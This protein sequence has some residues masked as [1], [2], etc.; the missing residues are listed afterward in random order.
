M[1][2][3]SPDLLWMVVL[4][5]LIAFVLA[6]GIGANDVANSFGTSVGS[7][8]LT[9]RQACVLA[10]ICE[11][12][13]AVLIGYKV[14]DT[15]RKGILEVGLYEGAE[16]E[17]MLGCVAALASSAIW[18]L[19]ATFLKL[20]ISGT[21]SIV[22]STIGFSL[23]ARGTQGLKW[24]TLATI[25][26][27]WFISPVMSGLV[28]I[29]LFLAIRKFIL[30]ARD[31]LKAGFRSLP[32]FYGVTFFI[33][34]I[35]VVLD[36]PKLLYMD[37]I[38]TGI[39]IGASVALSL[40][41]AL[42]TQLIVVPIQKRKIAKQLRAQNPVKFNFED[43]VESSPS[44]SPKKNRRPLSLVSDG[45]QLPAIAEITELVSLTDN[46]PKTFKL[47]PYGLNKNG[48]VTTP[49]N[50]Y[51]AD[52]YKINPEIIKKAED[53]LGKASLD[54]TDLTITSL[55]FID[56][57][58]QNG[59]GNG[60]LQ[61]GNRNNNTNG[62]VMNG[63]GKASQLQD[64]FKPG[65]KSPLLD[66]KSF[67]H[68]NELPAHQ[69]QLL[70]SNQ[71]P[72]CVAN[73][74]ITQTAM[75]TSTTNT[76]TTTLITPA[77]LAIA[78]NGDGHSRISDVIV[79]QATTTT[80]E[81][82]TTS[83]TA[84]KDLKVVESGSSLE[85]MITSTLSPN[86]SK[87][88]L[89]ESK[90]LIQDFKPTGDASA[91]NDEESEEVSMLFSF[92]QILTATFGSFAHGG[93]DVSN[94]IG[95]LIALYMIY[96]E[97]SVMQKAES[98]IYILIYGGIGI[99][100]GLWLWGRRVI[101]TIGNDLT[102]ITSSTGFTIEVGAAIT[103]LLASKIGLPISTTH[104]KVG[105]V[106]FVGHVSGKGHKPAKAGFSKEA[107]VEGA[108]IT[109]S[110]ATT[111]TTTNANEIS[112]KMTVSSSTSANAIANGAGGVQAVATGGDAVAAAG[113]AVG[114]VDWHL[115]RNIAYAWIVTVPV[116]ALLSAGIMFLMCSIVLA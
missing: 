21:H 73:N 93:N 50:G 55:N 70:E 67:E 24:S 84:K 65:V 52:G 74:I 71:S 92:L 91:H 8:V 1:D 94:A 98:P 47:A 60:L 66:T 112:A 31:P 105:S 9:I 83:T 113:V 16:E 18:L 64:Y 45:K 88:P 3:L 110:T 40:L 35:S 44:G 89:I 19:V 96:R 26:G 46:S 22:G 79:T 114:A 54:N 78:P 10:T 72:G 5:F 104:C 57:Q 95:P 36:G 43:S 58:Y 20:P 56:E 39:A 28:S 111:P 106:V 115:F 69:Q 87:I 86:S 75:D 100:V 25:V 23:V 15:M 61:N 97:G 116:T 77:A 59:N 90:E 4:G 103:V 85:M 51:T 107:S 42:L 30:R 99:S 17:L 11:I 109:S 12:S 49:N 13:G 38:P 82:I 37:N 101:E 32:I 108:V 80:L 33:N 68:S 102:K 62:I 14:S 48:H 63:A 41:V 7:G 2:A 6:F 27:S 76:A 53:L 29:L 81:P 34:V